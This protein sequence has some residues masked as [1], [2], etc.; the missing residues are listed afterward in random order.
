M[1][2]VKN[3]VRL[4][5]LII[6]IKKIIIIFEG[7]LFMIYNK[8]LGFYPYVAIINQEGEIVKF[9]DSYIAFNEQ[10]ICLKEGEMVFVSCGKD[11][12]K[13]CY[14]INEEGKFEKV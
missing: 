1:Q 4:K 12:E 2:D 5:H 9:V 11:K 7:V 13:I 3:I 14:K 6:I 8:I 10:E